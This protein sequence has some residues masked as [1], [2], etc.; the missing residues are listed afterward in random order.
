MLGILK[1]KNFISIIHYVILITFLLLPKNT[2]GSFFLNELHQEY[3]QTSS[4]L[5]SAFTS[6]GITVSSL[7]CIEANSTSTTLYNYPKTF[8]YSN[9]VVYI[10]SSAHNYKYSIEVLINKEYLDG[11][12]LQLKL[13]SGTFFSLLDLTV[14]AENTSS[15]N[16][17]VTQTNSLFNCGASIYK[18]MLGV[19]QYL[20]CTSS[21]ILT[22]KT[23]LSSTVKTYNTCTDSG[24]SSLTYKSFMKLNI[25]GVFMATPTFTNS[26]PFSNIY[27]L[28]LELTASSTSVLDT[29]NELIYSF[30]SFKFQA[31][32]CP[33]NCKNCPDSSVSST[34][35]GKCTTCEEN[36]DN[37]LAYCTCRYSK[38][39][40]E[41]LQEVG[42]VPSVS[43]SYITTA[44]KVLHHNCYIQDNLLTKFTN[45]G[46]DQAC[47]SMALSYFDPKTVKM[48][49]AATSIDETF[50]ISFTNSSATISDSCLN[51]L[52][53]RL[54]LFVG[55]NFTGYLPEYQILQLQK[56]Y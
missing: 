33:N 34:N 13:A 23:T 56:E 9:E 10:K 25:D 26:F 50:Q 15:S 55:D 8:S 30:A 46:G 20:D 48:I 53:A 4:E 29:G 1:K 36:Y 28:K 11:G 19:K 38:N 6:S 31:Y 24:N 21:G 22:G 5:Q 12:T 16:L 52:K 14:A 18:L 39:K 3:S 37:E 2:S 43:T 41:T 42:L 40:I 27:Q 51:L 45:S 49:V 54:Y 7:T 44:S 17:M 35:S 47:F 32:N